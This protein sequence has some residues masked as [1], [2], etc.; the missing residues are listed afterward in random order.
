MEMNREALE[1]SRIV[2]RE[3]IDA[4]R[5]VSRQA[6]EASRAMAPQALMAARDAMGQVQALAPM[7]LQQVAP[8]VYT[9]PAQGMYS[10]GLSKFGP[11]EQA[12]PADS[13]Y[14][15]ASQLLESNDYRAAAQRFK[16]VQGKYPNSRYVTQAMY[17]QAFAL[18]RSDTDSELR[19]A[20]TVLEQF[21]Q[22]Y[23]NARFTGENGYQADAAGLAQRIRGT[24][25]RR[26]DA[27]AARQISQAAG[28]TVSCDREELSVKQEALSAYWR[29]NP[30]EAAPKFEQV[31]ARRDECSLPLRR[32]ALQTVTQ[33]GDEKAVALLL[34][35][36][37]SDPSTQMRADAVSFVA[38]YPSD[39]VLA[40]L[41]SIVK[42]EEND[43]IR[44]AAARNLV[45]YPSPRAR[46]VIRTIIE[47]NTMSDNMRCEILNRFNEDR[48][49]QEDAAWLR[50]SYSKVT[51][52]QVKRCMV[53]AIGNIGGTE[54]QKWLID[55]STNEMESS[56]VRGEAFRRSANNM[57]VADLAKQ[58]DNAGA[59]PMRQSVIEILN[60][61]KEPEALD[62]LVDIL[63]K[64]SDF[65]IRRSIIQM[66]SNRND[67]K[68]KQAINDIIDK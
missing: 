48:G 23:P 45:G 34:A 42:N 50:T 67:P 37:K 3:Q 13:L 43:Q 25:A 28:G 46:T 6:I 53:S 40:T 12:D 56:A 38:R 61:R 8:N 49:N 35:T 21:Q 62:K 27:A 60:R 55:L 65:E 59:R 41:E 66:L 11:F 29:M 44:R 18:Y 47:D 1:A 15:R 2:T 33:R 32:F 14:R 30:A 64:T 10:Q 52:P 20:L 17:W 63:K 5:E 26:G 16:E 22:K 19:E 4:A 36:A 51:S 7:P 68:A 9:V 58:Y 31:L 54:N 24:L 39:E 57:S